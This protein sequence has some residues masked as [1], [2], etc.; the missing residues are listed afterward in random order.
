MKNKIKTIGIILAS[1]QSTRLNLSN[2]IKQFYLVDNKM[3]YEYSLDVFLQSKLFDLIY[4]VIN[5]EY[6]DLICKKYAKNEQIKVIL[7]SKIN[8]HNSFINA[9]KDIINLGYDDAKIIVH[10]AARAN[11]NIACLNDCVNELNNHQA[12]SLYQDVFSTIISTNDQNEMINHLDRNQIKMIYTPQGT[13]LNLIKNL[14]NDQQDY[15]D[16][17]HFLLKLKGIKTYLIK[18][19]IDAFKITTNEDLIRFNA[20]IKNKKDE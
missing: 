12:V 18:A 10:D 11:I 13:W 1:G 2:Q 16:L 15:S 6:F 5:E 19:K 17:T 9:I 14:I 7:G 8:R 4:L 3:I 20:L